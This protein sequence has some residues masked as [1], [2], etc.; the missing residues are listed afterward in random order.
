[1]EGEEED[2]LKYTF[3]LCKKC[4]VCISLLG[5]FCFVFILFYFFLN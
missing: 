2:N 4:I 1:M 5:F 3:E